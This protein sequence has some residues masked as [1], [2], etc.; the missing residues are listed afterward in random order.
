MSL[1]S[2]HEFASILGIAD[3]VAR[4]HFAKGTYR[5]HALPVVQIPGQRGGKGGSVCTRRAGKPG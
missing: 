1:V 5:G 2:A 3:R 4:R